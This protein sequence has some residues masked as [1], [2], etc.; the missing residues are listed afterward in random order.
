MTNILSKSLAAFLFMLILSL[1]YS[2]AQNEKELQ[3]FF[4]DHSAD[5]LTLAHKNSTLITLEVEVVDS[6]DSDFD[7]KIIIV[8]NYK[9]FIKNHTLKC[10]VYFEDYPRKFIWGTDTNSFEFNNAAEVVLEELKDKWS[11]YEY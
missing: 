5:V 11:K 2:Y 6:D 8:I 9:G 7:Y 4:K 1:P 3:K 10:Y